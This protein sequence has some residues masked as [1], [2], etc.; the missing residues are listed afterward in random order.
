MPAQNAARQ[1]KLRQV[2]PFAMS[3]VAAKTVRSQRSNLIAAIA[4]IAV[5]DI[6]LGLTFPLMS[7][8]LDERGVPAWIIG[9]NAAMSPLGIIVAG[10]FIPAVTRRVGAHR[11]AQITIIGTAYT[12]LAFRTFPSLAT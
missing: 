7:F 12:L 10:P 3:H 4:T 11:L 6:A 8:L 2:E 9:L 5:C 1:S